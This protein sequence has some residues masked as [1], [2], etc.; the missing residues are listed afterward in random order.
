MTVEFLVDLGD[1]IQ[2]LYGHLYIYIYIFAN[3]KNSFR[4]QYIESYKCFWCVVY[5]YIYANLISGHQV[6]VGFCTTKKRLDRIQRRECTNLLYFQQ[7]KTSSG[8]VGWG[9]DG[10]FCQNLF[11]GCNIYWFSCLLPCVLGKI[12]SF[13]CNSFVCKWMQVF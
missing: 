10:Y 8:E 3:Y 6:S 12:R 9:I 1:M 11:L 2:W 4:W 7:A 13:R 5:I